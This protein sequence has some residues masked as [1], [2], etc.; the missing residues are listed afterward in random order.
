M[1]ISRLRVP[2]LK[3][4][5]LKSPHSDSG[6]LL[7]SLRILV[8]QETPPVSQTRNGHQG[9]ADQTDWPQQQFSFSCVIEPL[10][11][12]KFVELSR[13]YITCLPEN[14]S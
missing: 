5:E 4:D 6:R 1:G 10:T 11:H 9:F 13:P 2:R 12:V 14:T 3:S 8:T 7:S